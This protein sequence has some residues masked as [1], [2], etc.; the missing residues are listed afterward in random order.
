MFADQSPQFMANK[1]DRSFILRVLVHYR[2]NR[3][4]CLTVPS[5]SRY[6]ERD[7]WRFVAWLAIRLS[8]TTSG[9]LTAFTSYPNA[10]TRAV[11]NSSGKRV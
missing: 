3:V 11:G 1:Y 2:I 4:D 8:D 7:S 5:R 10:R 9:H 6:D